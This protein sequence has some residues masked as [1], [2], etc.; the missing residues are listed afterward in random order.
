MNSIRANADTEAEE[1]KIPVE[2]TVQGDS[3]RVY[4]GTIH[5]FDNR[6]TTA[7]GTIRARARFDNKD[8]RLVPGMF[9]V[10]QARQQ[11]DQHGAARA[12]A[13]HRQRSE[14]AVRVRGRGRQQ[15]DLPR[16][17]P[18]R[19]RWTDSASCCRACSAG[20][21]V[22]V[23]GLQHVQPNATVAPTEARPRRTRRAATAQSTRSDN[24]TAKRESRMS[25]ARFFI[26]RPIFAGV[27]SVAIFLVGL[28][29][30]FQLPISEYPE[31]VPPSVV[32][33]A[34]FPGAK[35]GGDRRDRGRR[36]SRS[37]STA[38]RTCSTCSR[39][40]ATDGTHDADRHL[41]ARHRSRS[42]DTAG[43]EP[44]QPGPAAPAGSHAAC[45]A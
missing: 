3:T 10:G 5:S 33:R 43:A 8:G 9:V 7:S 30:M 19:S 27:I 28:I 24:S 2:L 39:S 32:V 35:P 11:R 21:R 37:R 17:Q 41:Q 26:D 12:R 18:G 36:R 40:A 1:R 31:I 16:G 42:G 15:S 13:R 6:I 20:E 34:Q 45:S 22:I 4:K 29:A 14:Q 38:S 23:D 44:R 25:L